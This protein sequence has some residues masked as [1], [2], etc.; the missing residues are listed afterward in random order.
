MDKSRK[1]QTKATR[2]AKFLRIIQKHFNARLRRLTGL[3]GKLAILEWK[4]EKAM[5]RTPLRKVSKKRAAQNR[6]Y[7]RVRAKFLED[8]PFCEAHDGYGLSTQI[9]HMNHREGIRLLDRKY[10]LAVCDECHRKIHN[11][12]LW[13][14][15][16]GL[17]I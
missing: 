6:E 15:E 2:Q 13:A 7:S 4:D 11:N 3:K 10:F 17:L 5:K 1:T 14:R 8:N 9:H 12:P 16:H